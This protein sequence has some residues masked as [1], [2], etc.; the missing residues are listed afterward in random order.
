MP[1]FS[2]GRRGWSRRFAGTDR[3]CTTPSPPWRG[4]GPS[5]SRGTRGGLSTWMPRPCVERSPA[6][7]GGSPRY[8]ECVHVVRVALCQVNAV[9][10]DLE[11]NLARLL[12][13]LEEAEG[14]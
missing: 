8:G 11:G 12:E 6:W 3:S 1:S 13:R 14:A 7:F 4:T 2:P 9:V 10:G 5:C